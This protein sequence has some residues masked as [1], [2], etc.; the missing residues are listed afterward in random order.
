MHRSLA[1]IPKL[2]SRAEHACHRVEN[3]ILHQRILM[4]LGQPRIVPGRLGIAAQL[5]KLQSV[6]GDAAKELQLRLAAVDS[7]FGENLCLFFLQRV[8]HV[9]ATRGGEPQRSGRFAHCPHAHQPVQHVFALLQSEFVAQRAGRCLFGSAKAPALITDNRLDGR[10]QLGRRHHRN[11]HPRAL[12]YRFNHFA[13][14]V[15]GND[16]AVLHRVAADDAACRNLQAEDRIGGRRQLM[17]H[18]ARRRAAIESPRI[19]LLQNDDAAS[20]DLLV[21]RLHR[22]GDEVGEAH[23]GDEASALIH[24]QHRLFARLSIRQRAPCRSACRCRRRH[25]ES[26]RSGRK[27]RARACGLRPPAPERSSDI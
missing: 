2:G 12:E 18:L 7:L 23:V 8:Q 17:H 25:K 10:Q 26:V 4:Q 14:I 9:K 1:G 13:V 15:V 16:D 20:L 6:L 21:G 5:Q 3:G 11:R 22:R 27:R 24:L 19:T